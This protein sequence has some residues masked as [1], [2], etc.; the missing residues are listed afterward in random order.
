MNDILYSRASDLLEEYK[1]QE[2]EEVSESDEEALY[3]LAQ[4]SG[5]RVL[6]ELITLHLDQL[7]SLNIRK[8][9]SVEAVGYKYLASATAKTYLQSI[10]DTVETTFTTMDEKFE[11][12]REQKQ[13]GNK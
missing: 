2:K 10:L 11:Q 4:T 5:W 13:T 6:K 3:V 7:N 1:P 12:E 8:N 9:D